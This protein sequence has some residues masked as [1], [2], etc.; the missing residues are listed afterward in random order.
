MKNFARRVK[1]RRRAH[2]PRLMRG[3][4]PIPVIISWSS[5]CCWFREHNRQSRSS[6]ICMCPQGWLHTGNNL[7]CRATYSSVQK[8]IHTAGKYNYKSQLQARLFLG[9]GARG[10]V[11]ISSS[12]CIHDNGLL[13]PWK[14]RGCCIV[15]P[16][17]DQDIRMSCTKHRRLFSRYRVRGLPC[18]C[19][20]FFLTVGCCSECGYN[21]L[22]FSLKFCIVRH[23]PTSY[24]CGMSAKVYAYRIILPLR[25]PWI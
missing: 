24:V 8:H 22:V 17:Y 14:Y 2:H 18:F 10:K 1:Q 9:E 5:S 23:P 21:N 25:H 11:P 4:C 19:D 16:P 15:S 20:P 3:V 7:K 12:L 6:T 13:S